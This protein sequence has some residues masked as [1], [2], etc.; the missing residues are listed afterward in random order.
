MIPSVPSIYEAAF[1]YHDILVRV[2]VLE[3]TPGGWNLVEV[4]SGTKFKEGVHDIDVAIQLLV[5][6]G[7]GLAVENTGLLTLNRDYIYDGISLD[8]DQ[9]F[10]L[11]D[12]MD[13]A[14]SL[15]LEVEQ[16]VE[17]FMT[18]L[19]AGVAPVVSPGEQCSWPYD[20][21]YYAHCTRDFVLPEHPV[22]ELPRIGGSSLERLICQ[23]G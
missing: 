8:L 21:A 10:V 23:M 11:H 15:Q 12:C 19:H 17:S 16:N 7:A 1:L 22:T 6:R 4:K 14:E 18:M 3:R 5:L 20:C 9:L 2:D 13:I